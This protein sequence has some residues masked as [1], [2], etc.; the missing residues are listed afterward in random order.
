MKAA[1]LVG[2]G[3]M[4]CV[5]VDMPVPDGTHVIIKTTACGICGSDLHYWEMGVGMDGRPG[6]IMGHEFSGTVYDTGNRK[7]LSEG[8]RVT[9]VPLNYCGTCST[10]SN[11]LMNICMTAARRPIPGNNSPGALAEFVQVRPD[12]VRKLPNIISDNAGALIEPSAVALH[13]INQANLCAGDGLLIVGGGPIGLLCA[14]WAKHK[15]LP[16]VALTESDPFRQTFANNS[17]F[18]DTVMDAQAE[19]LGRALRDLSGGGFDAAI[20]TSAT[21]GGLQ[22]ALSALK[23]RGKMVL[24][25]INMARQSVNTLMMTLKEV[26]MQGSMAYLP[27]EFDTVIDCMAQK[28]FNVETLVTSTVTLEAIPNVFNRLARGQLNEMKIITTF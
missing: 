6:L 13:A 4:A 3:Q 22:T 24:A 19:K 27:D 25:G 15:G 26:T 5:D 1:K 9:V 10:C 21:D 12:M 20:E 16:L 8:N 28:E 2:P 17:G 18:V 11:G 14:A 23:P 7:D